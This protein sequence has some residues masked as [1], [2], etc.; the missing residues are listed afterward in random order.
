MEIV[1][2][3][4]PKSCRISATPGDLS[5]I[6]G[7]SC[8]RGYQ[9]AL[10]ELTAP[11]RTVCTTVKTV[12]PEAPVLPVKTSA[13]IP[14]DKIF[15]LMRAVNA[16]TLEKRVARGETVI[17]DALSLGVDVVATSGLLTE[18]IEEGEKRV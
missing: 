16:F 10:D 8:R 15:D 5:A 11:K 4:C 12:F 7:H 18:G 6:T 2:I 14:K 1:C 3:V 17:P 9:F 13:G